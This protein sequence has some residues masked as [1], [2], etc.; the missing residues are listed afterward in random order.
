[1]R[2]SDLRVCNTETD[3]SERAK[4]QAHIEH[5]TI[6]AIGT[7]LGYDVPAAWKSHVSVSE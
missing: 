7:Y 2:N 3:E 4:F 5:G 1:M 6:L